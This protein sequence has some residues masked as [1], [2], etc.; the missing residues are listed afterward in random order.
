MLTKTQNDIRHKEIIAKICKALE[1]LRLVES[2]H[3]GHPKGGYPA[4]PRDIT[5]TVRQ[6]I[7]DLRDEFDS[8]S[9]GGNIKKINRA[10]KEF[11]KRF[12][13]F[14]IPNGQNEKFVDV[15]RRTFP[16]HD[17]DGHD[18]ARMRLHGSLRH[19]NN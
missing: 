7:D 4:R 16:G 3:A 11:R 12:L 8:N 19:P 5:G 2:H 13:N 18:G 17:V 14:K 10:A 15:L 6:R 1:P 9:P